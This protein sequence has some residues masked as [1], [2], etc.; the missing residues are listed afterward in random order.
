MESL[1]HVGV[2]RQLDRASQVEEDGPPL[3][4]RARGGILP[5]LGAAYL[6]LI[7]LTSRTVWLGRDQVRLLEAS[8]RGFVYA[9]WHSRQAYLAW[10]H[11]D[12]PVC[13]LV[14]RSKDGTLISDTLARIGISTVRGS[15][16]RGGSLAVKE[17]LRE[18]ERGRRPGV[19][20]DGPRGPARK[21]KPGALYL[22]Q[23]LGVPIIPI[24]GAARRRFVFTRSWDHF[25][26]P[27]PFNK[28][29]IAHG[30]PLEAPAGADLDALA[31]ELERRL[32]EASSEADREA[33]APSAGFHLALYHL[34]FPIAALALMLKV[35][36]S[37]RRGLLKPDA[38]DWAQRL[39]R[40]PDPP[41]GRSVIWCHASSVGEVKS[42]ARVLERL[43][44]GIERPWL[45]VTTSTRGGRQEAEKLPGVDAAYLA[46][47]DLSPIV[48]PLFRRLRPAAY[49]TA[50]TEIWPN[51][52]MA[53]AGSGARMFVLNG[54]ISAR[55]ARGY[56]WIA[57]LIRE[58]LAAFDLLCV[59]T[60]QDARRYEELGVPASRLRVVG[61]LKHDLPSKAGEER[62]FGGLGWEG[63]EAFVAG[64]T[65]KGE[66]ELIV[67]AFKRARASRPNLRLVLAPRHV[68]R[69][70]KVQALVQ[71]AGLSCVRFSE[72]SSPAVQDD[73]HS[74]VVV[75]CL[76]M[77]R[78]GH[79]LCLYG[80]AAVTFVGGTLVPKGG[81]NLLE[82]ASLGKPVIFGPHTETVKDFADSLLETGG[83]F[84]ATDSESL[85]AQIEAWLGDPKKLAAAGAG[86]QQACARFQG[87]TERTLDAIL[88]RLSA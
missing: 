65:R 1:V 25:E 83:G 68:E 21:A 87:A 88:P 15:S 79:L 2:Q 85:A 76:L 57:P 7:G 33:A 14:S 26:A 69:S 61:N 63:C 40:Y 46:P 81:H 3:N 60:S 52:F 64:S 31:R 9:F 4:D 75:D 8:G 35:L 82:P 70:P 5:L 72:L 71:A 56:R 18:A 30:A 16:S 12:E 45:I 80:G 23:R 58:S 49:F 13:V 24:A 36:L 54:R 20:P 74:R 62:P 43:R 37:S 84:Q 11:R 42:L 59:Q 44:H 47:I 6:R 50:E 66:E 38:A 86:A 32:D 39:G 34:L 19:T 48:K 78:M 29:V 17:L 28:L 73:P 22:A 53:A 77:D 51:A 41:A 10:A 27:L 67:E 55:S